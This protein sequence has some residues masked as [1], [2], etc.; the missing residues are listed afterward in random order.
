[1][2]ISLVYHFEATTNTFARPEDV[3]FTPPSAR[4]RQHQC[5]GTWRDSGVLTQH[6][7]SATMD[8]IC[9]RRFLTGPE[10]VICDGCPLGWF[11]VLVGP[12]FLYGQKCQNIQEPEPFAFQVSA[13]KKRALSH[14]E[15][16]IRSWPKGKLGSLRTNRTMACAATGLRCIKG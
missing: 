9:R 11:F 5:R 13:T 15:R 10:T 14:A 6:M 2:H 1:M 16:R 3:I 4:L 7:P 8:W 12:C